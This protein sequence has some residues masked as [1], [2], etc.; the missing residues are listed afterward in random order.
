MPATQPRQI[1]EAVL[2]AIQQSGQAGVLIS[3]IRQHPR[4][5]S[6]TA[7]DGTQTVLSVYAWTLTPGGRPQLEHEYRIQMT[8]VQSPL[9]I[10]M[11]GLTVLLGYEPNLNM[12]AGFDLNRHRTFTTGSPSVQVDIRTI[13]RALQDGLAFDRKTNNEIAVGIRP[14]QLLTYAL[15]SEQLHRYGRDAT[16]LRLLTRASSL[17][18]IVPADIAA[19][20]TE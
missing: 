20:S 3:G 17:E 1:V 4:K 7:P 12:F 2:D 10:S 6:V 11:D 5:F 19:L 15:N 9:G 16:T 18:H 8:S 13:R 14:D